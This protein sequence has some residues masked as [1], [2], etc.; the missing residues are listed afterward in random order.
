MIV[1]KCLVNG[2]TLEHPSDGSI[3]LFEY[4]TVMR[5]KRCG[6]EGSCDT[7][8]PEEKR[9]CIEER[10]HVCDVCKEPLDVFK[11]AVKFS[12]QGSASQGFDRA[13]VEV[14]PECAV[15][16][17]AA[18]MAKWVGQHDDVD[19]GGRRPP[20]WDGLRKMLGMGEKLKV[21]K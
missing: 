4:H 7:S 6:A 5:C 16:A 11:N 17:G 13:E 2:C 14:H 3:R 18:V 21:V 9:V 1:E 8:L 19:R 12:V 10:T 15:G 20:W